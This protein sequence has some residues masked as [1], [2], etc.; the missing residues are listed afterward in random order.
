MFWFKKKEE[1]LKITVYRTGK[2]LEFVTMHINEWYKIL[3]HMRRPIETAW[4]KSNGK[5]N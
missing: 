3:K 2:D 4:G 1:A 5:K